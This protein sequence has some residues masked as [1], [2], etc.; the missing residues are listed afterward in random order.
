MK[1]KLALLLVTVMLSAA[2]LT[3]CGQNDNRNSDEVTTQET[4]NPDGMVHLPDAEAVTAFI[5][6]VYTGVPEDM[7]PAAL[8]TTELDLNDAD[9]VSYHTGLTDTSQLDGIYVS[10]S[11][12]GSIAYSMVYIRTKEGADAEQIKQ[13]L[14]NNVNPAKWI[15]VSAEK[16]IAA[17]FGED[18]FF[19]MA[20]AEMADTVYQAALKAAGNQF[21][22]ISEALEK[23]NP[24]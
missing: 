2:M 8:G 13:D 1:K 6:S 14:F 19:V 9:M 12:I 20:E 7:T 10:E 4:K 18:V 22:V 23:V 21:T 15:C 3:A 5:D 16:M 24:Q 11:M 17:N